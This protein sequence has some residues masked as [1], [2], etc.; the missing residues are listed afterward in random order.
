MAD[1][2]SGER[3]LELARLLLQ[4]DLSGQVS[5]ENR[6][7]IDRIVNAIAIAERELQFGSVVKEACRQALQERYATGDTDENLC[8]LAAEIRAGAFDA[9]GP[10][11]DAALRLL[12][13]TTILKLRISNPTYLAGSGIL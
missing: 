7:D 12:W 1:G 4:H 13:R 8:R 9:P 10:A 3:L 6:A 5:L 2:P 11:R